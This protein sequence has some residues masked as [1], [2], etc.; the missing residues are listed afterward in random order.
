MEFGI[1]ENILA[2]N[3]FTN[4]INCDKMELPHKSNISYIMVGEVYLFSFMVKM[5]APFRM[6]CFS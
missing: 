5:Y 6:L 1:V 4:Y 3:V 2:Q